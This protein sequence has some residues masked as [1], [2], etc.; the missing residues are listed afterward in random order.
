[1]KAASGSDDEPGGGVAGWQAAS[2][3]SAGIHAMV[4]HLSI[5]RT[6]FNVDLPSP[7]V[8]RLVFR[9][10]PSAVRD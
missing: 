10:P 2:A 5:V 8:N 9:L 3:A 1:V 7:E 4:L 6:N